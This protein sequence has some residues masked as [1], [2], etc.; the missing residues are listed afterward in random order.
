MGKPCWELTNV[1]VTSADGKQTDTERIYIKWSAGGT[2][3][4]NL[5]VIS[6]GTMEEKYTPITREYYV[7]MKESSGKIKFSYE[8][9]NGTTVRIYEDR[10]L[11]DTITQSGKYELE[12]EKGV[13]E[14]Q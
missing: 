7:K 8:T 3:L 1:K 10:Q 13:R 12:A 9:M 2:D 6:G 11:K 4:K 5:E 14:I